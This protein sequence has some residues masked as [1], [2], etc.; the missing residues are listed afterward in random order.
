[1]NAIAQTGGVKVMPFHHYR[2]FQPVRLSDRTWPNRTITAAPVWCSVD[3]RDGNQALME[4]MGVE[5]K[6]RMFEMLVRMGFREIEVGFPAASDTE[7]DFIRKLIDENRIPAG[8]TIQVLTQ[9]REALIR[10]TFE[11]VRGAKRVIVHA[12]NSTSELQRRVVFGMDR[13]G[14]TKIA[15][16]AAALIKKLAAEQPETYWTFQYSPESF[17]GT[18]LE[19]AR[20]I[21]DAVTDVW[22]PSPERK[23]IINLPAT[24]EM[25][26]P[27]VYADMI[28]W[29]H[30]NLARRDCVVLSLH[31]HNDRGTGVAA[32][33]LGLMAGAD[34]VEGTL[35]GNGERT[36]NVDIITLAGNLMTQG[37]NPGLDFSDITEI[38]RVFEECTGMTV[39]ERHPYAGKLAYTAFSGGHQDA[40]DKGL[41]ALRRANSTHFEVPYL[42]TDPRDIGRSFKGIVRVNSQSG[43]GGVRHIMAEEHGVR[44][45]P[46]LLLD[47]SA[48]I[49]KVAVATGKEVVAGEVWRIFRAEY[50]DRSE[51]YELVEHYELP[52]RGGRQMTATLRVGGE[53]RTVVGEGNGAV[54]AL[55]AVMRENFGVEMQI[56]DLEEHAIK[57]KPG[58][59]APAIA[60][61]P[62]HFPG[63]EPVWGVGMDNDTTTANLRA[64]ISA[65]NRSLARL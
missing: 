52:T 35:F 31:T 60:F 28:E 61:V 13:A 43:K 15:I 50:L 59:D 20:D 42:T 30:R 5:T 45:P 62:I 56:L 37:V 27:N 34:R 14:I 17:T 47:F 63:R 54:D 8:V 65:V 1:M 40:V 44:L 53:E 7:F 58:S 39:H 41:E 6:C 36:G 12:Y 3:L 64:V 19:F 33:E 29:M 4:P 32:T 24:V 21:C 23:V 2:P 57:G 10:R 51:P 18:E 48:V 25:S 26:T 16:D 22:Q 11:A 49:Q 38:V 55:A 9:A 46:D